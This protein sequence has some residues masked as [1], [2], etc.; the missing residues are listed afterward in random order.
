V[1]KNDASSICKVT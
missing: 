1:K